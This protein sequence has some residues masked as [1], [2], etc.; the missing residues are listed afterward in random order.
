MLAWNGQLID[1]SIGWQFTIVKSILRS[2]DAPL[3]N[4]WSAWWVLFLTV[5]APVV[6]LIEQNLQDKRPIHGVSCGGQLCSLS[7]V[8]MMDEKQDSCL[9]H[10]WYCNTSG[11]TVF[12]K[13]CAIRLVQFKFASMIFAK[14][15]LFEHAICYF[16]GLHY[17]QHK[18]GKNKL[19]AQ[20]GEFCWN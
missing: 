16:S 19:N 4:L 5:H 20:I 2:A 8:N 9:Q 3:V 15:S 10:L 18:P 11:A 7:D 1:W 12:S 17:R 13:P 6:A 14:I